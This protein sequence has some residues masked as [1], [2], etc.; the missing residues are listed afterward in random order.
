MI[1]LR[2]KYLVALA[3]LLLPA[4]LGANTSCPMAQTARQQTIAEYNLTNG[5]Q[6]SPII[7]DWIL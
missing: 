6:G 4:M 7:T 3:A 5:L 1:I 2:M